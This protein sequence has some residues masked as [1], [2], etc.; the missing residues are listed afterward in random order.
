M[1]NEPSKPGTSTPPPVPTGMGVSAGGGS[2]PATTVTSGTLIMGTYEIE[3]LINSGGMG[4]VYRG[5]NIHNGEPVAIKIVLPSLAHDPK[6]VALFQKES[7]TL[8]RL[9][10]DAIVRYH[11][12]TVDPTIGRP[13]MVMEFV[14][15]TAMSDRIEQ[16]PMPADDVRMMLRRV[17]SGLDKAHRAG[18]VHRDLSP[19]NVILEDGN[20][21]HA[22][23]IDFGIAK[24]TAMGAGTLLQGQFAGK[25]NWVAPEQLGAFGGHVD[26]RSDIYSLALVTAAASK[27]EVLP[28]GASIVDAVGKRS[29][30]PDLTGV[31][32]SL[33][34][35]LSWML[36]PDP[37]L[38]PGSM[39]QVM[40]AVDNP[41]LIPQAAPPEAKAV[42]PN[43]TVIGG[44]LPPFDLTAA[45][46]V[47]VTKTE[48]PVAPKSLPPLA[49]TAPP[50]AG[51]ETPTEQSRTSPP[52]G[53]TV[54]ASVPPR[55][56][57][58]M[59]EEEPEDFSPFGAPGAAVKPQA[60]A[61]AMAP[62]PVQKGRGGMV[63]ALVIL[64][65]GAGGAG[66]YF[67]GVFDQKPAVVADETPLV[68]DPAADE[69][70]AAE[71]AEDAA[72]K[73]AAEKASADAAAKVAAERAAADAAAKAAE[74]K[75]AA[76][77]AKAAEESAAQESQLTEAEVAA[78][79]EAD[80][81]LA[82]E[83]AAQ[84]TAEEAA[85]VAAAKTEA[86]NKAAEEAAAKAAEVA[87][88]QKAA[89]DAA[90]KA[91]EEAAAAKAAA[92]A[93]A[94]EEATAKAAG[95]DDPVAKQRAFLATFAPAACSHISLADPKPEGFVLH[96][97]AADTKPLEDMAAA[98]QAETG[99]A[100]DVQ[101]HLINNEQCAL[102]D[103]INRHPAEGEVQPIAITMDPNL[104]EV[105]KSGGVVKGSLAGLGAGA[106]TLLN[107]SG[108][109]GISNLNKFIST[110]DDGTIGFSIVL[111]LAEGAPPAP[112]LF[113]VIESEEKLQKLLAAVEPGVSAK[114]LMPF[115]DLALKRDPAPIKLGLAF[116][117][118]EN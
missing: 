102:L 81:R 66:A 18:V 38:R 49:V 75:A 40:A 51:W 103:F 116:I 99:V 84:A 43:R 42:D 20:V 2:K 117:R 68:A 1:T 45:A 48:P 110:T 89:D 52:P 61:A 27:G 14:S 59:S 106:L 78:K 95:S 96:G 55:A 56:P 6:I 33:V 74:E 11:V 77:A 109:G 31:D 62:V 101:V 85:K 115:I 86:D 25:F 113:M 100:P 36:Q 23:L 22:K 35:L 41:D 28:M 87:A 71:A 10:H 98:W 37:S 26:G 5:R 24:S 79:A 21:E 72:A 12:F 15:G 50:V 9:N 17:A 97:F 76:D 105:V 93:K 112:Q 80:A 54:I 19:D 3:K 118:L 65:A 16:G 114:A 83:A 30:V 94:A 88:A 60:V 92:D 7:T 90:V 73:A 107:V 47:A 53:A 4:E 58:P 8:S 39:A 32:A 67:G 44:A 104:G 111:K 70:K 69:A 63:A 82:E 108:T 34:P 13:C 91:A 46:P 29:S 64:V 57:Q